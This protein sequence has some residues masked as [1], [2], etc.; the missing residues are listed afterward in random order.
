MTSGL[1]YPGIQS[2]CPVSTLSYQSRLSF[3]PSSFNPFGW[4]IKVFKIPRHDGW[5]VKQGPC[6]RID[7]V[8]PLESSCLIPLCRTVGHV[9][10]GGDGC[11]H[12]YEESLGRACVAAFGLNV[13]SDV[14]GGGQ[15]EILCYQASHR[16]QPNTPLLAAPSRHRGGTRPAVDQVFQVRWLQSR[17]R[18]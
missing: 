14:Q 1:V 2:D 18:R 3:L 13:I 10:A 9:I 8:V 17:G 5:D 7:G 6:R 12:F 16:S 11:V 4:P 15:D